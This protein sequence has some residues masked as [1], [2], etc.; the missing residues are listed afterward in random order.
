MLLL[1]DSTRA[2]YKREIVHLVGLREADV[3]IV[4]EAGLDARDFRKLKGEE[5]SIQ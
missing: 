5:R 4:S 1:P 3:V 2:M